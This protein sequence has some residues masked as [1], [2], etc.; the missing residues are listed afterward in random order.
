MATVTVSKDYRITIPRE[1]REALDLKPGQK[2]SMLVEGSHVRLV[3]IV[4]LDA[5]QGA[6]P[7]VVVTGFREKTDRC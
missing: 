2:M 4:G 5:L 3:P 7:E 1:V 6:Y